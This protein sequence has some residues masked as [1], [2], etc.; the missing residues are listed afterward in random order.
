MAARIEE[1]LTAEEARERMRARG[2][3]ERAISRM[4]PEGCG[5]L[6]HYIMDTGA[7]TFTRWA[8]AT[9]KEKQENLKQLQDTIA[10]VFPGAKLVSWTG[11]WA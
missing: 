9:E 7:E 11:S 3:P 6:Q 8:P 10:H 1:I 4:I 5:K 2:M